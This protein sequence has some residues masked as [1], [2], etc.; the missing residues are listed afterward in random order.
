[1]DERDGSDVRVGFDLAVEGATPK[2]KLMIAF[3]FRD[4]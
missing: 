4:L 3:L 1:V 2:G